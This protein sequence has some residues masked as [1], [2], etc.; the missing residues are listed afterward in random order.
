MKRATSVIVLIAIAVF[1]ACMFTPPA[2]AD[3]N[4]KRARKN[5][6]PATQT[7]QAE[8][9]AERRAEELLLFGSTQDPSAKPSAARD[10]Q[11]VEDVDAEDEQD[12]DLPRGVSVA[13]KEA[14]LAKRSAFIA[15]LRGV[16]PGRPFDPTA[17]G[18][19]IEQMERR[20]TELRKAGRNSLHADALQAAWVELGPNTIPN[21]QTSPSS[22]VSGR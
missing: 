10:T 8:S 7:K 12:P 17:R 15:R 20:Q 1:L 14:F 4:N 9:A 3:R 18:R 5:S 11:S 21:G 22:A 19:A 6:K 16:E 2:A 13:D